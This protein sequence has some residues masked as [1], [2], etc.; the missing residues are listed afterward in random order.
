MSPAVTAWGCLQSDAK[1]WQPDGSNTA[2]ASSPYEEYYP[3]PV[4]QHSLFLFS[5]SATE[6]LQF[7]LPARSIVENWFL[8]FCEEHSLEQGAE[9]NTNLQGKKQYKTGGNY[10]MRSFE[11]CSPRKNLWASDNSVNG[12]WQG[13]QTF[14]KSRK[15]LQL[16]GDW[17][18]TRKQV[19][20][21]RTLISAA[22]CAPRFLKGA[23]EVKRNFI[24]WGQKN[25]K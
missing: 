3:L 16:L 21:L 24:C 18:V 13:P 11:I 23:G 5:F 4:G 8:I 7:L 9:K 14:Q 12:V 17:R 25:R 19:N 15:H 22:T 2:V 20:I 1:H 10:T 6:N